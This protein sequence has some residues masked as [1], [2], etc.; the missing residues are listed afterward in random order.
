[1]KWDVIARK[2]Y[3]FRRLVGYVTLAQGLMVAAL[4]FDRYGWKWFLLAPIGFVVLF[5]LHRFDSRYG[6]PAEIGVS[7]RDTDMAEKIDFIYKQ[8]GGPDGKS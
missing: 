7:F 2:W 8:L 1:M 5:L 3:R 6:L 4:F